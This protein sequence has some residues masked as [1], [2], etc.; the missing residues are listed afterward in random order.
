[1]K[2]EEDY[3]NINRTSWNLKTEAH[4]QSEFYDMEG[5]LNG[6]SSLNTLDLEILGSLAGKSVLHLQ[7]HFGQ[8]TISLERL[9][10][11][12]TGVDLSEV[13]IAKAKA[14]AAS[15]NSKAKFIQ[16]DLYDL[17]RHL[18]LE[19]DI[20]F[21]SYGTIGW[22][23][24]LHKWAQII[25]SFLKPKGRLILIEFH[26]VVWMFNDSFD[27][28]AY[29]YFNR[30][31]IKE[32]EK[33]TYADREAEITLDYIMWNHNLGEVFSS[34]L[35]NNMDIESFSEYDYSPYNIFDNMVEIE[36]K[37][38][39]I[40]SLEEKLPMVYSLTARKRPN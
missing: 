39:V 27:K 30:G 18:N 34:V 36:K 17:P 1:M 2:E 33:G 10:A 20:V 23:P 29:S 38:Y 28:L 7:C 25:N 32:T 9:G 11:S 19:F 26:P 4:Y 15:L 6:N 40:S 13:A 14:L 5:F 22:L 37:K 3:I 35:A 16:C 31:P 24:D 8:D 12:V 21:T